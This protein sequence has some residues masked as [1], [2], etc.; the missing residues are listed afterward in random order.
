MEN[1]KYLFLILI[2]ILPFYTKAISPIEALQDTTYNAIEVVKVKNGK[3]KNIK[4]EKKV[5]VMLKG[6]R[7]GW[8]KIVSIKKDRIILEIELELEK[9]IE[10]KEVAFEDIVTIEKLSSETI[11]SVVTLVLLIVGVTTLLWAKAAEKN[12]GYLIL[13]ALVSSFTLGWILDKEE[14]KQKSLIQIRPLVSSR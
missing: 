6:N 2:Y 4:L 8:G 5:S 11:R 10:T 1:I 12:R 13:V 14:T 9:K 7:Y 3:K